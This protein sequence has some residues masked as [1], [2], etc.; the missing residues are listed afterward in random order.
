VGTTENGNTLG[1]DSTG[2]SPEDCDLWSDDCPPGQ[3]CTP[4]SSDGL[5]GVCRPVCAP[6][7]DD[8]APDELCLPNASDPEAFVCVP[9]GSGLEDQQFAPCEIHDTCATGLVCLDPDLAVECDQM[10]QGC[11]LQLCDVFAPDCT[12]MGAECV[13]WYDMGMAPP[14]YEDVGVCRLP[15]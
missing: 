8:C 7:G 14:E 1:T 4:Y 13:P 12:G 9:D 10:A 15:A 6:L 5:L 11:C 2:P 3:K